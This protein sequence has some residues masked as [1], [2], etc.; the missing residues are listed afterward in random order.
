[1]FK[2]CRQ[3]DERE[4]NLNSWLHNLKKD[5]SDYRIVA[6]IQDQE[7][8]N[9]RNIEKYLGRLEHALQYG[10]FS[11]YVTLEIM[12]K[13]NKYKRRTCAQYINLQYNNIK[14]EFTNN[15]R[16]YHFEKTIR[17]LLFVDDEN[18]LALFQKKIDFLKFS[19]LDTPLPRY[20]LLDK[21]ELYSYFDMKLEKI[22]NDVKNEYINPTAYHNILSTLWFFIKTFDKREVHIHDHELSSRFI[23]IN[24]IMQY[25]LD[26]RIET[27]C[28]L[29]LFTVQRLIGDIHSF[30]YKREEDFIYNIK[31]LK[32][33]L[34][35]T[36]NK[37]VIPY[38]KQEIIYCDFEF[39]PKLA[40]LVTDVDF[41]VNALKINP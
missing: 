36:L 1:M 28:F 22:V 39:C 34:S 9:E 30:L 38:F 19:L 18:N 17:S 33:D 10:N 20:S 8:N 32:R 23:L 24:K 3:L 16:F 41:M 31:L 2:R 7:Q 4:C 40:D 37:Y 6:E 14:F 29:D 13:L 25:H 27:Y 5:K 26:N 15:D 12:N 21:L 35:H 11:P